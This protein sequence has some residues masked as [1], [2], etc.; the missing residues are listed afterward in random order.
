M[1]IVIPP[2]D[3]NQSTYRYTWD[4]HGDVTDVHKVKPSPESHGEQQSSRLGRQ[5][6]H[7]PFQSIVT[8]TELSSPTLDHFRRATWQ[9][10][11][12][13]G[14][15]SDSVVDGSIVPDYVVNFIRGE[16][17]ETL[18]RKKK[19]GGRIGERDVDIHHQHR[20]HQSRAAEFEGFYEDESGRSRAT[21]SHDEEEH[22]L[23]GSNEK[24]KR[25]WRRLAH[26]WR[27]G[28]MLNAA[29]FL[30]ILI[31][32]FVCLVL[33]VAKV[34][35]LE[36]KSTAFSGSCSAASNINFGLH[37]LINVFAMVLIAGANYLFQVLSSPT[38]T[39]V[40]FA[41]HHKRWLDIGV[42]STRNW[43]HISSGRVFLAIII[44]AVGIIPQVVA[45][46]NAVIFTSRAG[47]DFNLI[48]VTESFL[49]GAPF[50]NATVN[51]EGGLSRLDILAL[52]DLASRNQLV[53]LSTDA[54]IDQFSAVYETEFRAAL[55][56]TNLT[57]AGNS[58]VQ[59]TASG[60]SIS[61]F[62][63]SS[64][65]SSGNSTVQ[66]QLNGAAV[67]FCLAQP[68]EPSARGCAVSLNGSLLGIA[69]LLNLFTA[70]STV[71]ILLFFR[72][73]EPLATLGDAVA[74]FL[75]DPDPGT[76]DSCLMTRS[77]VRQG[78]WGYAEAKYWIPRDHYW[79]RTPSL[80]RW[81]LSCVP[82][83]AAVGLAAASMIISTRADR[84]GRFTAFGKASPHAVNVFSPPLPAAAVAA[85]VASLPQL[86]LGALYFATNSL[87]TTYYL[88]HESSL[89]ATGQRRPLRVSA[90]P[91]GS[92]TT[93]LYLTLP[94]PLSWLLFGLFAAMGFVLSQS[95]F[96]VAVDVSGPDARTLLG[97]GFS[98]VGL[99]VLLGLLVALA[100]LVLGLGCRRAPAAVTVDG[101]A[102]GNPLV[103]EGGSCSAVI[104]AR[105]HS[106]PSEGDLWRRPVTWGVVREGL[107]ME[108]G[109][110]AFSAGAV[111]QLDAS[112]SYA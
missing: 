45:R 105:C 49:D 73:F 36:G 32:G 19:N 112:R 74:S 66:V 18:A 53:N 84:D 3:P 37:A 98:G 59:T 60:T 68:V 38:R 26:G 104:A 11:K 39:E 94:R 9:G 7:W 89:F 102:M 61:K 100:V 65:S 69:V 10:R 8:E 42:P 72:G 78:R 76:R 64:K 62:T 31:T 99:L 91:E 1:E 101:R 21:T 41:H 50:S 55:L 54:C 109:H 85:L 63:T 111:G 2:R 34:R 35:I 15:D 20:P 17:P 25:G 81:L 90:D 77:D 71:A 6:V 44:L 51:N 16:T 5:T 57:S 67:Q 110:C 52:Q 75:R 27:G 58:L 12:K 92:Q 28:V 108:L 29:L 13:L 88:S 22:I 47:A 70:L 87:L 40:S 96:L 23:S 103:L 86:L 106:D 80:L 48:F 33:A 107:G 56:I 83:L 14:R 4:E 43:L 24:R 97:L 46:Y 30:W 93:S 79:I 95:V 82:W